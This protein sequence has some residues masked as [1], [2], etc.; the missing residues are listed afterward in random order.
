[1]SELLSPGIEGSSQ[2]PPPLEVSK[3]ALPS[4]SSEGPQQVLPEELN[5]HFRNSHLLQKISDNHEHLD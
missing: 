2:A 4:L 3:E 1:M 5:P